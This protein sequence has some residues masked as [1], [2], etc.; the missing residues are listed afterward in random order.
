MKK[1]L[2]E[3]INRAWSSGYDQGIK[4]F[5]AM[6]KYY[7]EERNSACEEAVQLKIEI[8]NLKNRIKELLNEVSN[9]N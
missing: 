8:K 7:R 1:N 5:N 9:S 3:V 4:E 2:E 6:I